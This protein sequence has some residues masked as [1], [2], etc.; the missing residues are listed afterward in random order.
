LLRRIFSDDVESQF[1]AFNSGIE[2]TIAVSER[3]GH[4]G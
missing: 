4:L 3:I 1:L 2:A